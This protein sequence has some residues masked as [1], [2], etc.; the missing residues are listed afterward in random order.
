MEFYKQH[1]R[2]L[3]AVDCVVFGYEEG[4]LKLLLY[5]RAFE[6]EKGN[7]SLMGG[8]VQENESSDQAACRVLKQ[9]TGLNDIFLEQ[10]NTFSEPGREPSERVV[11]IAYFALIK[12][13]GYKKSK[14]D[15]F[16]AKWW[17]VNELPPLIFDHGEMILQSLKK[18]QQKAGSSLVGSELLPSK[19][20]LLQLRKLYEAIY[21]RTFDP[22]NFRKKILS[23]DVLDKLDHKNSTESKK[24]AYYYKVKPNKFEEELERIVKY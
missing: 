8:F 22:G 10:V 16:G 9:T 1:P 17:P 3:V 6:P 5:P 11:S 19:F 15:E 13:G 23:L 2:F 18:L 4:E 21:Q 7:W 20:T 12:I 24:G 14:A